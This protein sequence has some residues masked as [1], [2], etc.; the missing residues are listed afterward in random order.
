MA[1]RKYQ[2]TRPV[3]AGAGE[4]LPAGTVV[5]FDGEPTGVYRGRCVPVIEQEAPK[6]AGKATPPPPPAE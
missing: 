4:R 5:E 3:W 1:K 2:L 6:R